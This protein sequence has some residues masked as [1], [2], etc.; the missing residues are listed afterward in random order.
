MSSRLI[1]KNLP[2]YLKESEL[3]CQFEK[4]GKITDL[5]IQ[6]K[7]NHHPMKELGCSLNFMYQC[8]LQSN[9]L[10]LPDIFA[11]LIG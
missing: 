4:Y 5:R 2:L 11:N 8:N 9:V 7:K 1:V 10:S 3:K 6:F